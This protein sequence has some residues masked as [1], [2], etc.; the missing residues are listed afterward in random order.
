MLDGDGVRLRR[1][2]PEDAPAVEAI[3]GDP[4]VARWSAMSGED[5]TAWIARQVSRTD[6]VS[7]AITAPADD[8]AVG[9]AA[10]GDHDAVARRAELSYWLMPDARGRGLATAACR[11]LAAWGFR[12]LGLEVILL[13]IDADNRPSLAV[14][15]RLGAVPVRIADH[16]AIDR[17][18]VR[19]ALI[20]HELGPDAVPAGR[21]SANT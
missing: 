20:L 11:T 14:A 7:L 9:K 17:A 6:G 21:R 10:L 8:R 3:Q 13:D 12:T 5:A 19:R 4:I 15:R 16:W 18:G 1:W 2:R